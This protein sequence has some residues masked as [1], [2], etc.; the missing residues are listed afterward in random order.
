MTIEQEN[1]AR[2][3]TSVSPLA[4]EAR[5]VVVSLGGRLILDGVRVHVNHGEV[6]GIIGPNGSG[7][8][9]LLRALA[10]LAGLEQGDSPNKQHSHGGHD[11]TATGQRDRLHAAV[12]R[13]PFLHC[14]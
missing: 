3:E 11:G 7:K 5:D 10:G 8:T 14:S 6:L 12:G 1:T 13:Q 9:T 4:L 2:G